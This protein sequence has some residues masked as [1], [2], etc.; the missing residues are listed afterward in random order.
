[1]NLHEYQAKA[2]FEEYG[3]PVLDH[4]VA[5]TPSAAKDA[6]EKLPTETVVV[7]AQIRADGR[8]SAGGVKLVDTPRE[9]EDYAVVMLG[10]H[11]VTVHTEEQGQRVDAVLVEE[12]CDIDKE[13]YLSMSIDKARGQYTL[14]VSTEGGSNIRRVARETPEKLLKLS[15]DLCEGIVEEY[16]AE[17]VSA[18][19]LHAD[20]SAQ[21]VA[22]LNNLHRLV[23]TKD[24]VSVEID[25]LVVTRSTELVCVGAKVIVDETM[26]NQH[27]DLQAMR[28]E[29]QEA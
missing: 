1:M 27:P 25:P 4:Y 14:T 3:I 17:L 5:H 21:F 20:L 29:A 6:A 10:T 22:L 12:T 16:C 28:S 18:L 24:L 19:R 11:L 9:A 8:G 23:V 13:L 26:L 2:L 15:L 7:K